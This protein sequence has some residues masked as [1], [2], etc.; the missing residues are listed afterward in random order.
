MMQC[1]HKHNW[2]VETEETKQLGNGSVTN[3]SNYAI[4]KH[5]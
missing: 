1:W 4:P 2:V 3:E 5:S